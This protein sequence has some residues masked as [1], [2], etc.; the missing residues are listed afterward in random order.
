MNSKEEHKGVYLP[1]ESEPFTLPIQ[2]PD[3]PASGHKPSLKFEVFEWTQ[4]LLTAIILVTFVFVVLVRV[5]GVTGASMEPTLRENQRILISNLFYTPQQGDVVV[6][7]K[8]NIHWMFNREETDEPLVKRVIAT[9]GQTVDID[10][11]VGKVYVDNQVVEEPFETNRLG[12]VA[13]P[14]TV[15]KGCVF[16]MGDNRNHSTDSRTLIVGMVD[17]RY[18]LGKVLLRVWPTSEFGVIN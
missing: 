3:L 16:V 9:E 6:F 11:D 8:K 7:T 13:F 14:V 18:I 15:P 10:I 17:T 5:I 2:E 4:A 12:D 1:E